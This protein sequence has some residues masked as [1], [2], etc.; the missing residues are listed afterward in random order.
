MDLRLKSVV[1]DIEVRT[2]RVLDV[3]GGITRLILK[4]GGR[5]NISGISEIGLH[6]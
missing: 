6:N 2:P 4:E 1:H 3:G 5:I